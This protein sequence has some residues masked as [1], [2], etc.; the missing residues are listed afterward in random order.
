MEFGRIE[1][2][3]KRLLGIC[4]IIKHA[5]EFI[6]CSVED[7]SVGGDISMTSCSVTLV[8]PLEMLLAVLSVP[9]SS[10]PRDTML[11]SQEE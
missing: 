5:T 7:G 6:K 11:E 2:F 1:C 8:L 9:Q 3:G 4:H 10:I